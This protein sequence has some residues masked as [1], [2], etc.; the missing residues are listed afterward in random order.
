MLTEASER[1]QFEG[2]EHLDRAFARGK[3]IIFTISHLGSWEYLAFLPYLRAYPCSVVVRETR[4]PYIYTWI[5]E[6][7]VRTRLNPITKKNSV[8]QIF[9]EL[10]Q[11]HLVALLTDQ[12][13]GDE[14]IVVNFFNKPTSTTS[15]PVR[16]AKRTGAALIPGYC[17][18]TAC[19]RYKII[20]KPEVP[21]EGGEDWERITTQKLNHLLE[22]EIL[23]HPEQWMWIHRRWKELQNKDERK[24]SH[25]RLP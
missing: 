2:T 24:I 16:I 8:R 12:W 7:R 3:G 15:I 18:R 22:K 4:N 10:R 17:L 14:G 6:L 23:N 5:Q 11:N 13:A 21:I 1:F 9:Y 25:P 19:G 20:I